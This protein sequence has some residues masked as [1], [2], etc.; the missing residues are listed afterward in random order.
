MMREV[1]FFCA[2][3]M[4]KRPKCLPAVW[5]TTGV[6]CGGAGPQAVQ[7][8]MAETTSVYVCVVCGRWSGWK[9]APMGSSS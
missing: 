8:G 3:A 6:Q 7:L 9:V 1:E 4:V 5:D 2:E